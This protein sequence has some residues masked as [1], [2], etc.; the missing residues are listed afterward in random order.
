MRNLWKKFLRLIGWCEYCQR[1]FHY[2]KRKRMNTQ[3]ADE[4]S[5]WIYCCEEQFKEI[6]EYWK[7]RWDDYYSG[8]L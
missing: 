1:I 8:I 4:E 5:N 2:P 6:Q 3:Y 7:E